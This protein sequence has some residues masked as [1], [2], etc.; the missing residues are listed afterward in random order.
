MKSFKNG[1][2]YFTL[3]SLTINIIIFSNSSNDIEKSF[4]N[5]EKIE[6]QSINSKNNILDNSNNNLFFE[7]SKESLYLYPEIEKE[8]IDLNLKKENI[9]TN[10]F[11]NTDQNLTLMLKKEDNIH[12]KYLNSEKIENNKNNITTIIVDN[13][14][15]SLVDI[16]EKYHSFEDVGFLSSFT[17]SFSLLLVSEVM[18]KTFIIIFYFSTKL[19]L[20]K[21]LFFSSIS[22][23]FMNSISICIGYS[24]PFLLY[25]S[26]IEW[27]ALISF[28]FLSFAYIN[29]AYY[30]ED[31]TNEIKIYKKL[32]NERR[33]KT[34][35]KRDSIR[36]NSIGN[37]IYKI[38]FKL[39][40]KDLL[41][42]RI[43]KKY[44]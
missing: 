9:K 33:S 3:I 29:E 40:I 44:K 26:L 25:R 31:E 10:D 17:R 32:N 20:S 21:L 41:K 11:Y 13:F 27:L 36:R 16:G 7:L 24:I 15:S 34:F 1:I 12:L 37:L 42:I 35:E 6:S 30:L 43:F 5:D 8:D 19:P 28:I 38:I 14:N 2:L 23:I 4:K 22:L 18:D 39:K